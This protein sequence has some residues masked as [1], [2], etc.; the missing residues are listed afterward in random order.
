VTP[1]GGTSARTTDGPATAAEP[2]AGVRRREDAHVT[3]VGAD[4]DEEVRKAL[5]YVLRSTQAKPQTEA[6]VRAKLARR[7]VTDETADAVL[8]QARRL[9]AVDDEALARALVE[10]RGLRRG[11]GAALTVIMTLVVGFISVV[12][13]SVMHRR[14]A[15]EY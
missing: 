1:A 10:E 13:L 7:G 9:K 4:V 15:V 6:E 11:Y 5:A 3:R 2:S 8:A 12:Y 14:K